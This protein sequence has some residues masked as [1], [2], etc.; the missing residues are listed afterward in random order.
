[1]TPRDHD[2]DHLL[3]V[4]L[5][6]PESDARA[7]AA[8]A[9][10]AE[11]DEGSSLLALSQALAH[12]KDT[13]LRLDVAA[14]VMSRV[15]V[16]SPALAGRIGASIVEAWES[17]EFRE[18]LRATPRAALASRG[19]VLPDEVEIRVGDLAGAKLPDRSGL[20]IPLPPPGSPPVSRRRARAQI[21]ATELGW[22]W[23]PPWVRE[24]PERASA[25]SGGS[26]SGAAP[27]LTWR[28]A[29]A[30]AAS[31]AVIALLVSR[32][33]GPAGVAGA[34]TPFGGVSSIAIAATVTLLV[35]WWL[36]Q[37]RK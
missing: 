14:T 28:V 18:E 3:D 19:A 23:G 5:D 20:W 6:A 36:T 10:L 33:G 34:A 27:R 16:W 17:P 31:F 13:G 9:E 21:A 37:R 32:S 7:R 4:L 29:M 2:L 22:L 1:L 12:V 25:R 11:S 15:P 35:V 30:A 8:S 24:E 26:Y